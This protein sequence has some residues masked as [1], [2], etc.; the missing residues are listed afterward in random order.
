MIKNVYPMNK[1][2]NLVRNILLALILV[3]AAGLFVFIFFFIV[4]SENRTDV[5]WLN[6]GIILWLITITFGIFIL[7]S[8]RSRKNEGVLP[9]LFATGTIITFYDILAIIVI[10]LSLLKLSFKV[11]LVIH[12]ILAFLFIIAEIIAYLSLRT[13]KSVQREEAATRKGIDDLRT[14]FEMLQTKVNLL[15]NDHKTAKEEFEK[16]WDDLKYTAPNDSDK[17]QKFENEIRNAIGPLKNAISRAGKTDDAE[18]EAKEISN[19]LTEIY[20][21]IKL[22]KKVAN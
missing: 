18:A 19:Q 17:A 11:L 4:P 6:F 3:M 1:K 16:V 9:S 13:A 22:R 21:L 14:E 2:D 20:A 12:L 5:S 7:F 10:L 8:S 15:S